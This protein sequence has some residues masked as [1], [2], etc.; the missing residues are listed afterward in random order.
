MAISISKTY[1]QS[2]S[3]LILSLYFNI[4]TVLYYSTYSSSIIILLAVHV[5]E[6]IKHD[7][8]YLGKSSNLWIIMEYCPNGNLREFLRSSRNHYSIEEETLMTDLS[9]V[10]GPKNLIY[11]AWQIAKGMTFLISRKVRKHEAIYFFTM[12]KRTKQSETSGSCPI[13]FLEDYFYCYTVVIIAMVLIISW[14]TVKLHKKQRLF[15]RI[16]NRSIGLHDV[17]LIRTSNV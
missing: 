17:L 11:L 13:E 7:I 16:V 1:Y 10:F 9:Q 14:V 2:C 3:L 12:R 6:N 8:F 5:F 4:S 15:S